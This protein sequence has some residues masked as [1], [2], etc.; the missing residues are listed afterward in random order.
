MHAI[1]I[2]P[3]SS[4]AVDKGNRRE[5]QEAN[6]CGK[7]LCWSI[8]LKKQGFLDDDM[9]RSPETQPRIQWSIRWTS[10][11]GETV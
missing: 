1:N 8:E 10:S 3:I 4:P 11:T 5:F 7:Y 2:H 6:I 9:E